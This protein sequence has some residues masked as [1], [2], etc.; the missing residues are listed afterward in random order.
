MQTKIATTLS[1]VF[2]LAFA[3]GACEVLNSIGDLV[4]DTVDPDVNKP[5]F[6]ISSIDARMAGRFGQNLILTVTGTDPAADVIGGLVTFYD[7]SGNEVIF[8]DSDWNGQRD[9]SEGAVTFDQNVRGQQSMTATITFSGLLDYNPAIKGVALRLVSG[10][11]GACS[12]AQA[13]IKA[14]AQRGEGE[15]CD[16]TYVED[17]CNYGLGCRGEPLTCMPSEAPQL[18]RMAYQ[19]IGQ[20]LRILV[21][22]TDPDDDVARIELTFF[23]SD[24]GSVSLDL[25]SDGIA[26]ESFFVIEQ[27]IVNEA[28]IFFVELTPYHT[29]ADLVDTIQAVPYDWAEQ[30][31]EAMS[32]TLG[33]PIARAGSQSCDAHGFERCVTG[34]VCVPGVVGEENLCTVI[35]SLR[36]DMCEVATEITVSRSGAS[37]FGSTSGV[38]L[39][40]PPGECV[41]DM[42]SGRPEAVVKLHLPEAVEHLLVTTEQPGSS[43][44]TVIYLLPGCYA[45]TVQTISCDDNNPDS[46]Q[47]TLELD[48]VAAGDYIVVIDSWGPYGGLFELF[49]QSE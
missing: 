47:S 23:N 20:E 19:K 40:E 43:F 9:A 38:S 4:S 15:S 27:G 36:Q 34:T 31:G 42:A 41:A 22:G 17:R 32:A 12:K 16:D 49:V 6:E 37:T 3:T 24:G 5:P 46:V 11:S 48:N 7:G 33:P 10:V 25:D 2:I 1:S 8:F 44:D 29:L 30:S 39:W 35:Q 28:G 45:Q 13:E 21:E 18:T 14:Q 26:N